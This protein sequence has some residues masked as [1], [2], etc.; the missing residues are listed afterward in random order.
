MET[1][2]KQYDV[3]WVNLDPVEGYEMS[4]TRPCVVISP[5]EMNDYLKTVTIAPLTS[6]LT[7]IF[8][9]VSVFVDG[10]D[11]MIAL[12]HIPS[13]SKSRLHNFIGSLQ[14]SEIKGVKNTIKAMLVDS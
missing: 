5:N 13:I 4:K 3:F 10:Q 9:R 11:G 12:D 1:K 8:W 14:A 7:S 6:N 2:V